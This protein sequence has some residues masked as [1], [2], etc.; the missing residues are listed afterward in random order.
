M[1]Y[2][3]RIRKSDEIEWKLIVFLFYFIFLILTIAITKNLIFVLYLHIALILIFSLYRFG[4]DFLYVLIS[5]LFVIIYP[6]NLF[7]T[8]RFFKK[9]PL[10][11]PC[12]TVVVLA[13]SNWR[14]LDAWI[15]P[16]FNV[17]EI[18]LLYKYLKKK[19]DDFS[20]YPKATL[21]DTNKIMSN[22]NIKEVYFYGHG[23]SHLF[24][25]GTDELLYYCE[26]SNGKY[27]K[28]YIHQMHCGTEDGKSLIDYVVPKNN[29]KECFWVK[30]SIT[31]PYIEKV[32]RKKIKEI[33]QKNA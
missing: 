16:N 33:D 3:N 23:T 1:I 14:R 10:N 22:K 4:I 17:G 8:N 6:L 29:K 19:G 5:P 27:K 7:Q 15:K 28:E 30:K 31:G 24:Q 20:F 26:F 32:L 12:H 21:K 25:L 11:K 2:H 9:V 18:K 13:H